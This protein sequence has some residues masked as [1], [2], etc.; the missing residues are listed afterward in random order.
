MK[1]GGAAPN[2]DEWDEWLKLAEQNASEGNMRWNAVEVREAVV[3]VA[4]S[5]PQ[6]AADDAAQQHVPAYEIPP[7]DKR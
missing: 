7:P 5:T 2:T 3:G 1:R 6:R 4:E